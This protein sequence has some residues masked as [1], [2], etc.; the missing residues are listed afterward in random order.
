MVKLLCAKSRVAPLKTVTI[1][2]LELCGALL[3]ARLCHKVNNALNIQ[4]SRVVLWCDSTV[5]LHWL[6]TE[7]HLLNN[8][9]ANRVAIVQKLTE[10]SEWRHVRSEVNP[11]DAISRGQ[12]PQAFLQNRIWFNEP[13]WLGKDENQWPVKLIQLKEI[14]EMRKNICAIAIS[15]STEI[16]NRYSSYR[17]LNRVVA[18]C[19]RMRPANTHKGAL[20]SIELDE[21]EI[22]ILKLVQ[23]NRFPEEIQILKKE[24][25]D[26]KG[27][28]ANLNPF[29]DNHGLIRVGGRLR[30]SKLTL[31]QKHPILIPNRHSLIESLIRETHER[32]HHSGV[33]TTL[34]I[35]RQKY[36]V[37]NGREQ[38]RKI[39][40]R[41]MRCFRFNPGTVEYKMGNL[42]STR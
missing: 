34:Y 24:R 31:T 36:W 40:R 32:H 38:V 8:F 12:L 35:L 4:P 29:M 22:C 30:N 1:S 7:P 2:R 19:R 42:P 16:I 5:V 21:A 18:Y 11:A 3:L 26:V 27:N 9:V 39:I 41:C 6:K 20:K 23:A 13:E 10:H 15:D 33:Q 14:P 37:I 25:V 28:I 17:K